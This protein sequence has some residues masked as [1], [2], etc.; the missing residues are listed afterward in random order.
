MYYTTSDGKCPYLNWYNALDNSIKLRI[1]MR[2]DKL[3][4]GLYGDCKCIA[5][6]LFELRCK[7][8]SGY[9]IYFTEQED[10]II[11]ILCAGDKSTQS[12]D[13]KRAKEIIKM[14]K[15]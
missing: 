13:I 10:I 1:D 6:D 12:K 4:E 11:L 8:G 7:F 5:Q 2:I 9:R 15:E 3:E 14:I